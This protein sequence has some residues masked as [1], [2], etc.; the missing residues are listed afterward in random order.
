[1]KDIVS[2]MLVFIFAWFNNDK[3]EFLDKQDIEHLLSFVRH[4][5]RR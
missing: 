1:M 5:P 3:L 4:K 2:Q